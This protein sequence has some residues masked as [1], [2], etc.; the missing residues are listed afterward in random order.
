[1]DAIKL[2]FMTGDRVRRLGL[3]TKC[4]RCP[5]KLMGCSDYLYISR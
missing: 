1:M 3:V 2:T 5:R 4:P